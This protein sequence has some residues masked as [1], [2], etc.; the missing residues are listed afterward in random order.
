LRAQFHGEN[1]SEAPA[2][3]ESSRERGIVR[4]GWSL[5]GIPGSVAAIFEKE[6]RYLSRSGPMLFTLVM[7]VFILF[8]FRLTPS[9]SH[10]GSGSFL[11]GSSD[12]G[13]SFWAAPPLSFFSKLGE[14]NFC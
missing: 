3:V 13:V 7:P 10:R 12:N 11:C 1:L 9:T 5:P 8:I 14:N 6:I 4:V 2:L